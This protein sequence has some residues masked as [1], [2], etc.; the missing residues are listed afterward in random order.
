MKLPIVIDNIIEKELQEKIKLTLLSDNFNWFFISD[1]TH[2]SENKQQRPGFQHRF[3][4]KEKINSDYHN[5][6]LPIIQNSCKHI[7]YDYK[8]I[9]QG[10]S[11][12]QLP[13]SLKNKKIDTPHI[14]LFDKHLV[15]LYYVADADGDTVIY[16]NQYSK[17]D[18]IPFFD[19]LQES[20]RVT[21]KQGRVVLFDGSHWHTSCQPKEKIRCIINYNV[22]NK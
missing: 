18:P 11:F 19:D 17:K 21:P 4:V 20:K 12:L 2:A 14:D 8:K 16:K 22:T 13:L 15:I 10:R 5:L 3:V 1:V 7:Q 6:V 9:I